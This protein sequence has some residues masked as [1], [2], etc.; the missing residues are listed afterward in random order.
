MPTYS[1]TDSKLDNINDRRFDI[2]TKSTVFGKDLDLSTSKLGRLIGIDKLIQQATK[3]VLVKKRTYTEAKL[4]GVPAFKD[5]DKTVLSS[6]ITESLATY[7]NLQKLQ[8][9]TALVFILGKNVYRT[10]DI[11][12]PNSWEKINKFVLTSNTYVDEDVT[13]GTTYYY[14]LVTVFTDSTNNTKETPVI[15][16]LSTLIT[17]NSTLNTAV[18]EDFIVV[19]DASKA[20]LYW[21]LPAGLSSEEQLR[22]LLE[23]RSVTFASDPRGLAILL[24]LSNK[25]LTQS[26]IQAIRGR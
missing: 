22:S 18:G 5:S 8:S 6:S 20:V 11:S 9:S 13:V 1:I 3:S 2:K 10:K 14:S 21:N 12:D 7:A 4:L 24:K 23:I 15:N 16:S 25:D 26:Q 19:N 17:S